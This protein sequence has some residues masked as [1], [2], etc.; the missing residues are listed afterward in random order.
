MHLKI[1]DGNAVHDCALKPSGFIV[2]SFSSAMKTI[3]SLLLF[4]SLCIPCGELTAAPAKPNIIFILADDLGQMDVGCFNPKTFYETPNI[5]ALAKRG[6]KFTQAYAACCVCS[7]T[8]GSFLTGRHPNRYG[9]FAPGWSLRPEEIT[10]AEILRRVGAPSSDAGTI[11]PTGIQIGVGVKVSG[12][13]RINT[14]GDMTATENP[15]DVAIS[16]SHHLGITIDEVQDVYRLQGVKINDKHIEVIVRQM[17]RRVTVVDPGDTRFIV[18]E[19]LERA[20]ILDENDKVIAEGKKPATF[21]YMLLGITK[22]SLSTDSFISAA[23]FQET[24]RVLTEAAIMGKRDEL[25]GLKE[26]VI[27]GRLIPAGTGLAYHQAR[28]AKEEMDAD[29]RRAIARQEAAEQAASALAAL[30]DEAASE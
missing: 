22:A 21:D 6:M 10:I 24:T 23:S 30:D 9:T 16:Y 25:R 3:A 14:Q 26:N 12:V 28:K 27:V 15:L 17:L 4:A 2:V 11:V 13:Y 8:R 18:G 19:Q 29:E 20:E 7:P 1:R 5:D